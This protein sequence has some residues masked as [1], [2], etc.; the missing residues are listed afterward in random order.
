[1]TLIASEICYCLRNH[2]ARVIGERSWSPLLGQP[3]S[4]S[5]YYLLFA[6]T[7]ITPLLRLW[8]YRFW[9]I[10]HAM[11]FS[12]Q[13]C[14]G[15]H[16]RAELRCKILV[17]L[18]RKY[19]FLLG[20]EQRVKSILRYKHFLYRKSRQNNFQMQ[21]SHGNI[22]RVSNWHLLVQIGRRIL[23]SISLGQ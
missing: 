13:G 23:L 10:S 12:S 21:S 4:N 19:T 1:M 18:L 6:R 7:K 17:Q 20:N 3:S 14:A 22:I 2:A 8:Q 15:Y 16:E 9:I 11:F 5:Q